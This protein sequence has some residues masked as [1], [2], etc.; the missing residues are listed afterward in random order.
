MYLPKS[1]SALKER[2]HTRLVRHVGKPNTVLWLTPPAAVVRERKRSVALGAARIGRTTF[3]ADGKDM[4]A[5][6]LSPSIWRFAMLF[7]LLARSIH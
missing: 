3:N 5:L 7:S 1:F 6:A 2:L 4:V